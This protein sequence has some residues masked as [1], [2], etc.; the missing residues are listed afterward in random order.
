MAIELMLS[1]QQFGG[2][3]WKRELLHRFVDWLGMVTTLEERA[4]V[5][6]GIVCSSNAGESP[7]AID[8]VREQDDFVQLKDAFAFQED[9]LESA[10]GVVP[11]WA[12]AKRRIY[13]DRLMCV[14]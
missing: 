10:R 14:N 3:T 12:W 9:R 7:S 5:F 2:E 11:R 4:L 13:L 8:R 6:N 1:I